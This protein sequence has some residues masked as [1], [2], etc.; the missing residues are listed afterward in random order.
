MK[1]ILIPI[2]IF[3]LILPGII[4]FPRIYS[5]DNSNLTDEIKKYAKGNIVNIDGKRVHFVEKGKNNKDTI[6]M[7]HGFLYSTVMWEK[8]I[9]AL[10][11]KYRVIAVDLW[12]WGYSERLDPKDYNFANYAREIIGLMDH[13]KIKNADLIG[14]SMGGA[15]STY[16][17]AHFPE[18][19]KKIILV[20]PAVLP[21]KTS[22]TADFYKLP[23]VGEFLNSLPG[24]ML[25]KNNIRKIFFYDG[26][27]AT[28]E[29]CAKVIRPLSIRN[30]LEGGMHVLRVTLKPPLVEKEANKIA[31]MNKPVLIIHGREDDDVPLINSEKLHKLWKTSKLVIFE[32]AR[33]S[34]HEEYPE[35]FNKLAME[36]LK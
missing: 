3:I 27:T 16:I 15:T 24:D 23:F 2:L 34:P 32:K 26:K 28:D 25:M 13:L 1:K 29:Y 35:K 6:I 20:D 18:R 36:F 31:G 7:I 22:I 5:K 4:L 10:A 11:L 33:H 17:A 21:Y 8:N 30:T 12:G 19:V 14:Q 9:D